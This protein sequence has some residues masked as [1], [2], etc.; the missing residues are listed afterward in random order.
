MGIII[1]ISLILFELV[2][3]VW[4]ISENDL[5]QKEKA[6]AAIAVDMIFV[7]LCC[8]GIIEWG[9]RY[10]AI[11]FV[12][13]VQT[14][15]AVTRVIKKNTADSSENVIS[16]SVWKFA[17]KFLMYAIALVPAIIFPQFK[18]PIPTGSYNVL[19]TKYTWTDESRTETY[20]NAGGS[21]KVT[22][23]V[24][25]PENCTEKV[26]LVIFSHGAFGFSGSNYSTCTELA[27][28]G[29]IV[30]GIDH[31]YH[32]LYT[33][34]TDGNITIADMGFINNVLE[35][36]ASDDPENEFADGQEWLSLR[37][38]D[39]NFVL[40]TIIELSQSGDPVFSNADTSK[41]GIFGHSL[42]GAAAAQTARNRNDISAVVNLDGT[43]LGDEIAIE[44]GRTICTDEPFPVPMLD[45]YSQYHYDSAAEYE[46]TADEYVNFHTEHISDNV[47]STYFK[48]SGHLNFTDLP[49]FSPI[50]GKAL[51]N[52]GTGDIDSLYCI[53]TM[54]KLTADY[55]DFALKG[56]E[57]P[58]L[59]KEY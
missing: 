22:V 41:I 23:N 36:N 50:L 3:L 1:L 34:D 48:G 25:Y 19:E 56:K 11:G 32:A 42:G 57:K 55:F 51:G 38:D 26:P 43:L 52:M 30:A 12:L 37:V 18:E 29:Y 39:I 49:L 53:N 10:I 35:N 47:D 45:I 28:R 59:E 6:A 16:K 24:W 33:A 7:V 9:F 8:T 15:I 31:T 21:R 27:S 17:V 54:N 14:V 4:N 2:F 20:S 40:D 5:H 46:N 58:E 13:A 44:N